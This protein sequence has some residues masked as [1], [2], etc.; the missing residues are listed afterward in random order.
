[1]SFA[2]IN[3]CVAPQI[4]LFVVFVSLRLSPETFGYTLVFI[5][6][7]TVFSKLKLMLHSF[8]LLRTVF[9]AQMCPYQHMSQMRS[10]YYT[11]YSCHG[12]EVK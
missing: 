8:N 9:R 3:L 11:R 5:S 12:K 4:A 1:V 7:F 10:F 6:A 2:A